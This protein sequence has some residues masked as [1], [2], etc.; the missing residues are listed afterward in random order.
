MVAKFPW[1]NMSEAYICQG[2]DFLRVLG[3]T[4]L[5]LVMQTCPGLH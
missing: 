3:G 1:V 5:D 2:L 4:L